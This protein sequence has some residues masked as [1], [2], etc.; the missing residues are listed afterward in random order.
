MSPRK[1]VDEARPGAHSL[2]KRL[3]SDLGREVR[4]E[5]L[6]R[7]WSLNELAN[8]AQLSLAAAHRIEMGEAALLDTYARLAVALGIEPAFSLH[9]ERPARSAPDADPVHAAMG[10]AEA[11]HLSALGF[12]VL[13]DE[14]Y[15]HY[16]FAGRADLVAVD[17][18]KRALLHLENRTRFPDIQAAIGSYNAKR[19]YLAPQ[20]ANRLDIRAGFRQ[21]TH[22][23]VALWSAEVLHLLRLRE[24][25]FDSVCP[26][27]A[28][29]FG[30]WWQGTTRE[31][32]GQ[33]ST[34]ILFDPIAG[35]RATRRRWV[36]LEDL[37]TIDPRYRGYSD[38]VAK[39]RLA[40]AA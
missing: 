31:Q 12:E 19:A 8:R 29:E 15:Q 30:A 36:G 4:Q 7:R 22:V 3:A 25:T 40:D 37:R 17:R 16:Q 1:L 26:D 9:T 39:L 28:E 14:P 20:L 6:R 11:A 2:G 21:V 5:R 24:A 13:L 27:P 18:A 34:L 10:E 33:K 35:Q 23:I 32:E 38:A